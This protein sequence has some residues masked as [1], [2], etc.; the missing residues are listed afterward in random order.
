MPK[1]DLYSE[2]VSSGAHI[3]GDLIDNPWACELHVLDLDGN[4]L[5]FGGEPRTGKS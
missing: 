5:R 4:L 1:E 3:E 2:F